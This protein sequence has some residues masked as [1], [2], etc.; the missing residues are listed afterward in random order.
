MVTL[1]R[2]VPEAEGLDLVGR[3]GELEWGMAR[4]SYE[5]THGRIHDGHV[6][7]VT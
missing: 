3:V 1:R 4:C 6:N 2:K 5:R 7:L